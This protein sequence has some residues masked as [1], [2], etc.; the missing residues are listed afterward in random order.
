MRRESTAR[1]RQSQPPGTCKHSI[2]A[3]EGKMEMLQER[4]ACGIGK[5]AGKN[6][7]P[8]N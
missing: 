3:P 1:D 8:N 7:P 5:D 2:G 4:E 6:I